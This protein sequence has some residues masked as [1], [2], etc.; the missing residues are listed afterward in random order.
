ML[1]SDNRYSALLW[2][3]PIPLC[4]FCDFR[5]TYP[6]EVDET[7]WAVACD[8]C[9]SIGPVGRNREHS[10]EQRTTMERTEQEIGTALNGFSR[11]LVQGELPAVFH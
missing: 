8:L 9:D 7:G 3:T 6:V 10:I 2:P 5:Q 1:S 4:P 11:R